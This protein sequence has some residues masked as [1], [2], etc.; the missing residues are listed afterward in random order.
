MGSWRL[1]LFDLDGVFY[2]QGRMLPGAAETLAWVRQ[3]GIPHLFLT[4]TSSRPR[5]AVVEKLAGMGMTVDES[6]IL[7]PAV[8][9]AAKAPAASTSWQNPWIVRTRA[10]STSRRART[11]RRSAGTGTARYL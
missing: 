7:T 8:A 5:S 11:M 1:I 3:A 9:A 6:E 10:R 4:N 2:Q